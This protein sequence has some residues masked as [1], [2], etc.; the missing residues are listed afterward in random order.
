MSVLDNVL[1]AL[2]L[3]RTQKV[4]LR[5]A[6]KVRVTLPEDVVACIAEIIKQAE[7]Q[8]RFNGVPFEGVEE[9]VLVQRLEMM[10]GT[11]RLRRVLP[12]LK[13]HFK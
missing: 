10:L 5:H 13:S 8:A 12:V 2:G 3:R 4:G 9:G 7:N 6:R 11:E 1:C